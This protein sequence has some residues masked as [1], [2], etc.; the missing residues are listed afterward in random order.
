MELMLSPACCRVTQ[1]SS[2][3]EEAY[4]SG[5]RYRHTEVLRVLMKTKNDDERR[6]H[7]KLNSTCS[8]PLQRPI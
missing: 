1:L 5:G 4:V 8:S 3:Y 6:E 7:E 2:T